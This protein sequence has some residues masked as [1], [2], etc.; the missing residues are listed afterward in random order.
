MS[1]V[2]FKQKSRTVATSSASSSENNQA[3]QAKDSTLVQQQPQQRKCG[4]HLTQPPPTTPSAT[5]HSS[6]SERDSRSIDT[7]SA[8]VNT[9]TVASGYEDKDGKGND[10]A[11]ITSAGANENINN[12]DGKKKRSEFYFEEFDDL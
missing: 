4:V 12:N 11:A 8:K 2:N 5:T 6:T 3:I 7:N 10:G 1:S 9:P